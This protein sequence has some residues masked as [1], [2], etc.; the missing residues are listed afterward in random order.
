ME[1][2]LLLILGE[3]SD[4]ELA[5]SAWADET[6]RTSVRAKAQV[7]RATEE[8][9]RLGTEWRRVRAWIFDRRSILSRL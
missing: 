2:R 3:M 1:E 4:E 8:L 9:V 5:D 6:V 7:D